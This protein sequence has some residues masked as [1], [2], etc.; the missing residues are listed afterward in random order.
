[1]G[2]AQA[3]FWIT[4]ALLCSVL[5]ARP[6]LADGCID[7]KVEHDVAEAHYQAGR[8]AA[9]IEA[10]KRA[11]TLCHDPALRFNLA[12]AYESLDDLEHAIEAYESYIAEVPNAP[13]RGAVE[14]VLS[15]LRRRLRER[16]ADPPRPM[17]P[18]PEPPMR[19]DDP[20]QSETGVAPWVV[21]GVGLAGLG[22]AIGLG[23]RALD[24]R[25]EATGAPSHLEGTKALGRAEDYVTAANVT[26]AISG[27]V[28]TAGVAWGIVTVLLQD[29]DANASTDGLT[30][31]F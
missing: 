14:Q 7:A 24:L 4:G 9:A 27:A 1:M 28:L 30:I 23:V 5:A 26:Y 17:A 20:P 3:G 12:R 15:T 10:L 13:N 18:A 2:R 21:A 22:V 29:A 19:A 31:R 11:D 6:A 8:F 16:S 25:D